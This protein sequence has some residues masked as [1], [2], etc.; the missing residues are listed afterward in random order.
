[1]TTTGWRQPGPR[2]NPDKSGF[3]LTYEAK[4]PKAAQCLTKDK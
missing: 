2:V 1:L 3:T 4:Y